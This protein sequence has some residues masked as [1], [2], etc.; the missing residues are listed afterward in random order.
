MDLALHQALT[1]PRHLAATLLVFLSLGGLGGALVA[2]ASASDDGPTLDGVQLDRFTL[3]S[4]MAGDRGTYEL[5][6]APGH[7]LDEAHASTWDRGL[8]FEWL[9]DEVVRDS[10]GQAQWANRVRINASH[11]FGRPEGIEHRDNVYAI[12]PGSHDAIATTFVRDEVRTDDDGVTTYVTQSQQSY[13]EQQMVLPCGFR[14]PLQG[15]TT[16]VPRDSLPTVPICAQ[17]PGIREGTPRVLRAREAAAD[18]GTVYLRAQVVDDTGGAWGPIPVLE[19]LFREDIPYPLQIREDG[20]P[21]ILVLTAF[22]RGSVPVRATP[23][24]VSQAPPPLAFAP[25]QA[26]G[27]DDSGVEHPLPASA[28]FEQARTDPQFTALRDFLASHDGAYVGRAQYGNLES[29]GSDG[30]WNHWYFEVTDGHEML[31]INVRRIDQEAEDRAPALKPVTDLIGGLPAEPA[32]TF[33]FSAWDVVDVVGSYPLPSALG[34]APTV[35]S[36]LE[37]W[38]AYASPAYADQ[39][40]NDWALFVDCA[41][42]DGTDDC[43]QADYHVMAGHR[44]YTRHYPDATPGTQPMDGYVASSLAWRSMVG[45]DDYTFEHPSGYSEQQVDWRRPGQPAPSD[46]RP[47]EDRYRLAP[48]GVAGFWAFPSAGESAAIGFSALA[49][50]VLYWLWPALKTGGLTLFSR[51]EKDQLL[52]NPLRQQLVSRIEAEPGIHHNALVRDL[53]KGKGAAEHHLDKLVAARL[54]LR[55]RGTGYTCYF[56]VG[57]DHRHMAASGAT[58]A[59]GARRILATMRNGVTGVRGIAIATGLSPSTVSHH[60]ERLRAAG[61]VAG[62]GKSGYHLAGGA[63]GPGTAAA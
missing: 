6:A 15:Q 1:R 5:R 42:I 62:D 21:W 2:N 3:E 61:L 56:P 31:A 22:E 11:D 33:D 4:P 29:D 63:A 57:T 37:Q 27:L 49:A 10:L 12:A 55:H 58:K 38:K 48:L 41:Y 34:E 59:D 40:P 39:A 53:G 13:H 14:N 20:E 19:Y 52:D 32:S 51:V 16:Q 35:A 60:L 9:A 23:L 47:T 17:G 30:T 46:P 25:L 18:N 43:S 24:V 54:V 50:A 28:A 8:S 26:W 36:M 44:Q 7:T 45:R